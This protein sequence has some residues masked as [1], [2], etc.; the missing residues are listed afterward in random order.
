VASRLE[1]RVQDV[2][3]LWGVRC[4]S[5]ANRRGDNEGGERGPYG[6][7]LVHGRSP[8]SGRRNAVR[9]PLISALVV[10]EPRR[11]LLSARANSLLIHANRGSGPPA[12]RVA[13]AGL[14]LKVGGT[15]EE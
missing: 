6:K 7:H 14:G 13:A 8:M 5:L 3:E 1:I 2:G 15:L 11:A 4:V 12:G 10:D 9:R